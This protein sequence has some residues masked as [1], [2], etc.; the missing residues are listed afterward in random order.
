MVRVPWWFFHLAVIINE[1]LSE[2]RHRSKGRCFP[3][4]PEWRSATREIRA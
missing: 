3:A 4:V 1:T 2:V